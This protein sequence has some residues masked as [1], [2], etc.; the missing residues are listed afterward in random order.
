[1]SSSVFLQLFAGIQLGFIGL[2]L[3]YRHSTRSRR[4]GGAPVRP[5]TVL[6]LIGIVLLF[7][8]IQ[9]G[10]MSL[11]P[12]VEHMMAGVREWTYGWSG[13]ELSRDPMP[14]TA[15]VTVAAAAFYL[16]GLLDYVIHRLFSHSRTFWWTH[17]YH[18]LPN[19]V[20]VALPGLSVRP[21]SVFTAIPSAFGTILLAYGT[22]VLFGWPLW[23]LRPLRLVVLANVLI[24]V[25]SHSAFLRQW[26]WPHHVL[27]RL[28]LTTPQEHLLH[29]AVDSDG[30]YGNVVT[31]W[32]RVFGTYLDPTRPEHADP[33]LGLSY[34]QD[35][36]GTL[37][38]GRLKLS[39]ATRKR[40]Q[41]SRYCN[42]DQ[43]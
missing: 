18:H 31:L 12:K 26:W 37:T 11:A 15:L 4:Y 5:S 28:G 36:L 9:V 43:G 39:K 42:L 25:T 30:N 20:F 27:R 17:E 19:Q 23:D 10:L 24:L 8:A 14:T 38:F 3:A 29:H 13:M 2:D 34:D 1:M 7:L 35:F 16:G 41:I 21:F 6:F 40:F 32:D 33:K 22:L